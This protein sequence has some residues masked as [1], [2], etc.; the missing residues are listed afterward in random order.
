MNIDLEMLKVNVQDSIRERELVEIELLQ[1]IETLKGSKD[2]TS[3]LQNIKAVRQGYKEWKQ[4]KSKEEALI[5]M[6]D[7]RET[8]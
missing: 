1:R 3:A 7:I 6:L 5:R 8:L 2:K 4:K